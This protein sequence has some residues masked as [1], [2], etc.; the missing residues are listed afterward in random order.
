MLLLSL[1]CTGGVL[2]RCGTRL[3]HCVQAVGID[4]GNGV[5]KERTTRAPPLAKP[6]PWLSEKVLT[7]HTVPTVTGL[8]LVWPCRQVRNSWN[9]DWGEKGF[10]RLAYGAWMGGAAIT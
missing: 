2:S 3:D 6:I 8:V 1:K 5:W 9:T 10:I 4:T 7:A